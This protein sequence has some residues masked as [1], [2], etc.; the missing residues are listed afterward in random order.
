M[1]ASGLASSVIL[2]SMLVSLGAY[3]W[4][5]RREGTY[6]NILTPAFA[7]QIPAYFLFQL[8]YIFIFGNGKQYVRLHLCLRYAGC[9]KLSFCV[10]L[11]AQAGKSRFF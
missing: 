9:F 10:R 4:L 1:I 5:S 2:A 11:H 3:S 7:I 8:G 6:I